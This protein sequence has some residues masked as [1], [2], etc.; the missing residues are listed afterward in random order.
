MASSGPG[1]VVCPACGR[2]TESDETR[3]PHCGHLAPNLFGLGRGLN[4]LLDRVDWTYTLAYACIVLYLLS[5]VLDASAAARNLFAPSGRALAM[6]GM[7]WDGP[8]IVGEGR[9]AFAYAAPWYTTLSANFL[10][11]S[12]LHILFNWM[13][14][15][16][17]GP[18]VEEELGGARFV[19]VFVLGGAVGFVVSNFFSG[20]PTVGASAS[21]FALLAAHVALGRHHGGSLG[22]AVSQQALMW[23]GIL[24]LIGFVM[25]RVNNF[26]HIGGFAGGYAITW[27][28]LRRRLVAGDALEQLVA[29]AVLLA[30]AMA[31][32]LSF[33]AIGLRLLGR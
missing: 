22:G 21:I 15:R 29:L 14:I 12:V 16:S 10:H 28:L 1:S 23:A 6:L 32:A 13:W 17:L 31:V 8:L 7:T 33:L 5:L 4:G 18:L 9:A 20:V 27:L 30:S 25:P 24:L 3:C 26:A 2:L 19:L 11:G